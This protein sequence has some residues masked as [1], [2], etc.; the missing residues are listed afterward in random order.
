MLGTIRKIW[1]TNTVIVQGISTYL[2]TCTLEKVFA[3]DVVCIQYSS[4]ILLHEIVYMEGM[5]FIEYAEMWTKYLKVIYICI[6]A[7]LCITVLIA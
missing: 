4:Y 5:W 1:N 6:V 2:I 7:K 3:K